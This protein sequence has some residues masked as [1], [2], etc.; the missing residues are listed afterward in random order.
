MSYDVGD[1]TLESLQA[2]YERNHKLKPRSLGWN[3]ILFLTQLTN[4]ECYNY[5]H[6]L[7]EYTRDLHRDIWE[8]QR[9]ARL[10]G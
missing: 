3:T 2:A 1:V 7:H 9:A 4:Q 8:K 5:R 10:T 6:E